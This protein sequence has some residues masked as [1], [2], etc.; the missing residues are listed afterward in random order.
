MS[1]IDCDCTDEIVCPYCGYEHEESYE[2]IGHN[3]SD[4]IIDCASC[5]KRF[6]VSV[7]YSVTYSTQKVPCL[8]NEGDHNWTRWNT[9]DKK[10]ETRYCRACDK[11]EYRDIVPVD[12]MF[13]NNS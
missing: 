2:Y 7:E 5:D 3:E 10:K 11:H 4:K 12:E 13:V 9:W 8:N 6:N 1:D